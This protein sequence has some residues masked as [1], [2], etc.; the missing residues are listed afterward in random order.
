MSCRYIQNQLKLIS[1]LSEMV[2]EVGKQVLPNLSEGHK[3][4][5]ERKALQARKQVVGIALQT[6]VA[7]KV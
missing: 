3:I 5:R 1:G 6:W 7:K 2:S 4:W